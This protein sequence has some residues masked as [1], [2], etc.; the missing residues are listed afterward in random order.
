MMISRQSF[1]KMKIIALKEEQDSLSTLT[2]HLKK[3]II[4]RKKKPNKPITLSHQ[5]LGR[6]ILITKENECANGISMPTFPSA[7]FKM[8]QAPIY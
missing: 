6:F 2:V 8:P 3:K 1:A 4:G 5:F 7:I